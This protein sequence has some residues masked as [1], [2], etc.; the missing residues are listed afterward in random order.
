MARIRAF[1][2]TIE[3]SAGGTTFVSTGGVN[4]LKQKVGPNSSNSPAQQR[5]RSRFGAIG[6]LARKMTALV[7][8][9]Y[10]RIGLQTG[11]SRFVGIN[12][13]AVS[14]DANGVPLIDYGMLQVSSGSTTPLVGLA[15]ASSATGQTVSWTNNSDGNGALANDKVYLAIVKKS[16]GDVLL[17]LGSAIRSATTT[18]VASAALAGVAATDLAVYAFAKREIG[19][20]A[21]NTARLGGGTGGVAAAFNTTVAGPNGSAQGVTLAAT[22]GDSFGFDAL[23]TGTS[24]PA[25]MDINVAGVQ[26]ASVAYLDRYNGRPFTY[27]KA[28][29]PARTGVFGPLAN[30]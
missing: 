5:Q 26:V 20:E 6:R 7:A 18:A 28:G 24:G 15:V 25:S 11:Y 10:K 12:T 14:L 30:F 4:I 29:Q 1:L 21:S 2:G 13:A 9:G 3:G 23:T 17:Q 19:G 8:A 16:T 27:T 22:A